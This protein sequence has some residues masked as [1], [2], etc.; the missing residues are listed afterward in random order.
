MADKG[1]SIVRDFYIQ[2]RIA[3][4]QAFADGLSLGDNPDRPHYSD[5]L[6]MAGASG[7]DDGWT[8]EWNKSWKPFSV[9]LG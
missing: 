1:T 9:R 5:R 4:R 8:A 2:G 6:E 7:W 3:G